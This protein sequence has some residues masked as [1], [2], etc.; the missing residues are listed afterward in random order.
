MKAP[1]LVMFTTRPSYTA[2]TSAVGG[3]TIN[4]I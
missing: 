2:P 1:N 3:S 4:M